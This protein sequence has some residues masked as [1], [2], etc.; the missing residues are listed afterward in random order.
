MPA[1]TPRRRPTIRDFLAAD[2][3]VVATEGARPQAVS[4]VI[5]RGTYFRLSDPIVR[6]HPMF[7]AV[8]VPVSELLGEI[9]R[10]ANDGA[11]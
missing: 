8:L 11:G 5:E 6:Q 2:A 9:E 4:S 7:F 3:R 1:L 10:G